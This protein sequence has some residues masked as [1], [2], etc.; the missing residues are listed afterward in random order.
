MTLTDRDKKIALLIVPLALVLGY[1][2]MVLGP[3][4]GEA[5]DL[6]A[7]LA[8]AEKKRDGAQ[9]QASQLE[10]SK[11]TY[12]KDYE[13][14]VRLGKAIPATLDMPS[15]IVQL[16]S[17][18]DGTG[19]RFKKI[20]AGARNVAPAPPAPTQGGSGGDAAAGGEK[21][22]TD[23]GKATEQA[24][25][26]A[27]T[28]DT[29]NSAAGADAASG[30]AAAKSGAPGLDSV[31]LEFSFT[32]SFFDLADF[33]HRTKRF[34][35]V[36]NEKIKVQGRLMTIDGLTFQA[37][38]FPVI[39]AEVLATVYLSPKSEGTTAGATSE[40]PATTPAAGTPAPAPAPA[41]NS[42]VA[43]SGEDAR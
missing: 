16:D 15:L 24:N 22:S 34:V 33:F 35:R 28:S 26:A 41:G 18:A 9:S 1:W 4:R 21:A 37:A 38:S 12:A 2:F 29:A 42:P 36:A 14:V 43:Q 3:K 5:T 23:G 20:R 10:G 27:K 32:G 31:P 19:I 17:A 39:K 40:G 11:N 25:E 8:Q 13:T 7:R 30:T 6:G